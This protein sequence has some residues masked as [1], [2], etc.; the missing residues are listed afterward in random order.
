MA[1][2]YDSYE[3][4][5]IQAAILMLASSTTFQSLVGAGDVTAARGRIAELDS[6]DPAE[7]GE[8]K[9]MACTGGLF[10]LDQAHA[11]VGEIEFPIDNRFFGH[12]ARSGTIRAC[13][14][15]PPTS[16]DLV[17]ER[18]RRALNLAG[19][20]RSDMAAL[21]GQAGMLA[22]YAVTCDLA[23]LLDAGDRASGW[24]LATITIT[25]RAP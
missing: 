25:W 6:G 17:C 21:R 5:L 24:H 9:G 18:Y 2:T 20:I 16:G 4:K 11:G 8:G 12:E 19:G 23:V 14:L 13:V 22:D 1:V 15:I 10:D 7:V 3:A